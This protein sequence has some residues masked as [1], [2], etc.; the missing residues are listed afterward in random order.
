M[1]RP[2]T[3]RQIEAFK[4]VIENGTVSRAATVLNVSQPA[5]SK[6]IAHLEDDT[7]LKLFDRVKGRLAPTGRGMRLYEE[8]GRIFAGVRQVE[9]AVDAI[10]REDRGQLMIGVLPALSGTVIQRATMAFLKK[11]PSVY[12]SI[13]PLASEWVAD[14]LVAR[15]LDVG[16][17]GSRIENPYIVSEPLLERPV[18]CA[19]PLDHPLTAKQVIVPQDLHGTPFVSFGQGSQMDQCLA[20]ILAEHRVA[21]R[22]AVVAVTAP[23]VLEFVAAGLGVTLAHPLM[24]AG[25][26]GRVAARRFAPET[27]YDFRICYNRESRNAEFVAAFVQEARAVAERLTRA[28]VSA[29]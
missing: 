4:A 19:M 21:P 15:K 20:G 6:M 16:L 13:H 23:T 26:G 1:Q 2:L 9:S 25:H 27:L 24:M 3:L 22:V 10:R 11:H 8:I 7:G 18:V 29:P 17:V 12:C 14:G 28:I 5:M